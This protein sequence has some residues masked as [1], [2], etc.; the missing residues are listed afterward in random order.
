[1]MTFEEYVQNE[2]ITTTSARPKAQTK[3]NQSLVQN[4]RRTN[5][6]PA[7][8]DH[9]QPLTGDIATNLSQQIID[10]NRLIVTDPNCAPVVKR[11]S[12]MIL[13]LHFLMLVTSKVIESDADR[14]TNA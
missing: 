1:M 13:R 8:L 12:E 4:L 7:T 9:A 6:L 11:I 10:L 3:L 2:P 14:I 5:V